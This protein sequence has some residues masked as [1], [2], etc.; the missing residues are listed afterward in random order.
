MI[1]IHDFRCDR[2]RSAKTKE[3]RARFD[4]QH[5]VFDKRTDE[6][7]EW[8]RAYDE[9]LQKAIKYVR[10]TRMSR[11]IEGKVTL[12]STFSPKCTNM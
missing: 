2:G 9:Q 4:R 12:A 3:R 11:Y 5:I 10:T 7:F 1:R 6:Y 8:K